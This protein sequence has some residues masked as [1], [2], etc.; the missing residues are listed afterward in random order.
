MHINWKN[1]SGVEINKNMNERTYRSEKIR[2]TKKEVE[3]E[4]EEKEHAYGS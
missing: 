1:R 3:Y 4:E 2:N